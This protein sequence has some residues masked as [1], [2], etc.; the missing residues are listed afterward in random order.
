LEFGI[1]TQQISEILENEFKV[2]TQIVESEKAN[3]L[4]KIDAIYKSDAQVYIG[5]SLLN[6]PIK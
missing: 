4:N 1:G 6:T 3:S 2:K 5:T